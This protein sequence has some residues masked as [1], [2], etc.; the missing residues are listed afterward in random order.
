QWWRQRLQAL[1]KLVDIVRLD[2]F[3]GFEAFWEIP[4]KSETAVNGRWVKGPGARFFSIMQKYLG[5]L[6]LIVEDLGFI[7]PEVY[8]LKY[9]FYFPGIHVLQFDLDYGQ[10]GR[11]ASFSCG[12]NSALY[13]GTHDNDTTKGWYDRLLTE[14]PELAECIRQYLE[15]ELG[16]GNGE[17]EPVCWKLVEFTY[18]SNASTLIV[19]LQDIL[20]LGSQARMNRPGTVGNNWDWRYRKEVLTSELSAKL[21]GLVEKYQ[22]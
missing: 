12:K 3:R 1:L 14:E 7:T 20:C 6:P 4:A 11:C 2:H 9:Q 15:R 8:D 17:S 22:R 10:S 18:K 16:T 19:P 13:T 5:D 21:A